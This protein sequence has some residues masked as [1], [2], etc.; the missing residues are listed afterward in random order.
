MLSEIG[1]S[2]W[3]NP[4]TDYITGASITP[5][6]F[7]I[8]GNDFSWLSTGRSAIFLAIEEAEKRFPGKKK[9]ALLPSYTCETVIE[10]FIKKGYEIDCFSVDKSMGLDYDEIKE[11]IRIFS[12]SIFLFHRYFG[13]DTAPQIN[14][15]V[16]FCRERQV[17]VIEDRTQCLYSCIPLSDA[18]YIV[19]SIR[20]WCEAP[21]GGFVVSVN[22]AI[23]NKP[24]QADTQLEKAKLLASYAK[25]EYL[26]NGIG[27]KEAFLNQYAE[28]EELLDKRN[29]IYR[30]SD[31]SY[32]VQGS[33]NTENL[34]VKRK[35]NYKVLSDG[36]NSVE[37]IKVMFP[38]IPDEVTP[39]YIPV[40]VKSRQEVQLRLREN[41]I[42][43][44]IIWP[45]AEC[46]SGL[47]EETQF[48][49][50]HMLCI[51]VDQRYSEDDMERIIDCLKEKK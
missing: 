3:I 26:F 46:L 13:F 11:K 48:L 30:I 9:R 21:D 43:A 25:Y 24:L 17:S 18:D 33:L 42:Y 7:G 1:S 37:G 44:P 41:F 6:M 23:K 20:K 16:D 39:L 28:A 36:L 19:G 15:I 10:P 50:D 29:K 31:F 47:T 22:G 8:S 5:A 27:E 34:K 14:C 49:Y 32:A 2:F 51:P 45:K 12:P 38:C 40:I 35:K 4:Q